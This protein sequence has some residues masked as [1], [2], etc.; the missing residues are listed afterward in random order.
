MTYLYKTV[1]IKTK[2]NPA[3]A[4]VKIKSAKK[5]SKTSIYVKWKAQ[6]ARGK[7][8]Y[9]VQYSTNKRFKKNTKTL[10]IKTTWQ[11]SATITKL[12]KKK[13]YYIRVRG[14]NKHGKGNWS[15]T[16]KVKLK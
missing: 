13:T 5:Y 10:K 8:G 3:P 12:K 11:N 7:S 16:M 15:K 14:Y 9:Y 1:K 6:T 4:T 2:K